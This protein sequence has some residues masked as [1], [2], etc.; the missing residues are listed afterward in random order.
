MG[1]FPLLWPS[2][3]N[4]EQPNLYTE[5][6][7]EDLFKTS[8]SRAKELGPLSLKS[9]LTRILTGHEMSFEGVYSWLSGL[10]KKPHWQKLHGKWKHMFKKAKSNGVPHTRVLGANSG[11]HIRPGDVQSAKDKDEVYHCIA[12]AHVDSFC[13]SLLDDRMPVI[14]KGVCE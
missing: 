11:P 7:D 1:W 9:W 2:W 12:K 10:G 8:P 4:K 14:K 6:T 5:E 13:D 3:F